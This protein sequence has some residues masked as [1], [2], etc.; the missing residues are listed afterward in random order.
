[1]VYSESENQMISEGGRYCAIRWKDA[2][3]IG[4]V[5]KSS[6]QKPPWRIRL[7]ESRTV[8]NDGQHREGQVIFTGQ[9]NMSLYMNMLTYI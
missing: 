8:V 5:P 3:E 7:Y 9:S 6:I 2:N 1:M 4:V